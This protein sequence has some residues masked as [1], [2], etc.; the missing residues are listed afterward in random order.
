MQLDDDPLT[1]PGHSGNALYSE[2]RL[3]GHRGAV[4]YELYSAEVSRIQL[5]FLTIF[6]ACALKF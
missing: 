5:I 2:F 1:M 6:D 3:E 4:K